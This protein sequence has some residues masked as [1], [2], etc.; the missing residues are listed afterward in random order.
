VSREEFKLR[1]IVLKR[2]GQ[3]GAWILMRDF[4]S[5]IEAERWRK[6]ER[7]CYDGTLLKPRFRVKQSYQKVK[8]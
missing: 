1:W 7:S 3:F 2:T 5:K 8:P 4:A 6:E